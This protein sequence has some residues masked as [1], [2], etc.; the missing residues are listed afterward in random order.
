MTTD[1]PTY[2]L[3]AVVKETG[4]KPDTLRA[5]ERRYGMPQ[6]ERSAGGHRLYTQKDID[7]L[8]WLIARQNEGLS[9]SRAVELWRSLEAQG[10]DPLA[11]PEYAHTQP[12]AGTILV[13]GEQVER[14][15]QAWIDACLAFNEAQAEQ[16]LSQAFAM[17]P[18]MSVCIQ[19]IQQGLQKIGREW[20]QGKITVHQ[21]HFASSLAMR[22][23]N[24]LLTA[25]PRP[26]RPSRILLACP[27]E[28]EHTI[29]L[30]LLELML[31]YDGWDVVNLG[32]NLPIEAIDQSVQ[33]IKPR[34]AVL[35]ANLLIT[36][37]TLSAMAIALQEQHV[38]VAF[39]GS[40]FDRIPQLVERTPGY[41]LGDTLEDARRSVEMIMGNPDLGLES[42]QKVA[43]RTAAAL[44]EFE[45]R[46]A[47]IHA[48][49]YRLCKEAGIPQNQLTLANL[50]LSRRIVAALKLGDI[51]LLEADIQWLEGLLRNFQAPESW[52][53]T[54]LSCYHQ[55]AAAALHGSGRMIVEWLAN[56]AE[57]RVVQGEYP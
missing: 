18:A 40:I 23:L 14:V 10:E 9:I 19:V 31:R 20:Y 29:G 11:I 41:F 39:G 15:R 13:S 24:T 3:K 16:I 54:Y 26:T 36:A 57:H 53:R 4:V 50:N 52:L 28:E 2:N 49:V 27:P 45:A 48:Q 34:L 25:S 32:A 6:P 47:D 17:Y 56:I 8:K 33:K 5:W 21:E 46:Q 22:R 12:E 30:K 43:P 37:Q 35:N 51:Q 42:V 55:A 38:P 44:T 7:T 1:G